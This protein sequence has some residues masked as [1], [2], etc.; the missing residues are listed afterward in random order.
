[1]MIVQKALKLFLIIIGIVSIFL[2]CA[3]TFIYRSGMASFLE[4]VKKGEQHIIELQAAAIQSEFAAIISDVE[5]LATENELVE[6]LDSDDKTVILDIQ[7]EY[8]AMSH[9]K[10]VYDQLRFLDAH[11]MEVIRVNE[12]EGSP[13]AVSSPHLQNKQKRYYFTGTIAL[14]EGEIFVSPLDL[15]VEEE[16]IETPLKPIIRF[17]TPVFDSNAKKRGVIIINYAANRLLGKLVDVGSEN[18]G[19]S[20]LINTEGYWLLGPDK[21][22]EWGFMYPDRTDETF[23]NQYP[24]EWQFI[25]ATK[26]GQLRTVNG[27]FSFAV[28]HPLKDGSQ[29]TTEASSGPVPKSENADSAYSW[30]LLSHIPPTIINNQSQA[31]VF[32]LLTGGGVLFI[33]I[34]FGAWHLAM[35]ITRRNLY[36]SQLIVMAM[37]DSLT[38]LPNRKLF[39]DHLSTG[40]ALAKRHN[41]TLAILYIDLDGFKNVNDTLGHEAGDELLKKT[42]KRLSAIVRESD[43]VARLG[44][45]EF[46]IIL[47]EINNDADAVQVGNKIVAALCRDFTL[48]S[49]TVKVGASVGVAI[50]PDEGCDEKELIKLADQ[51]MYESKAKGKNTCTMAHFNASMSD[52]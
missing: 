11:G 40:M 29:T 21:T 37:Y 23:S 20:M 31:L 34:A 28:I 42:G 38:G 32:K 41:R 3:A 19:D 45:D 9:A 4:E 24:K 33:L 8:I 47:T 18:H 22:K 30:V 52:C 39:F 46:A 50:C 16:M 13:S 49:G 36:Q 2:L 35:A 43:T 17:G 44:G 6:Y 12:N 25:T 10:K 5:F 7:K 1:M 15:N 14:A 51:A 27:L 48:R 26:K